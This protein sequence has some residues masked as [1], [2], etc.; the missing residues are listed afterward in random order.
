MKKSYQSY[1]IKI[2]TIHLFTK[3]YQLIAEELHIGDM[4]LQA[5]KEHRDAY[6]HIIRI[7]GIPNSRT[8]PMDVD[9]YIDS[10]FQDAIS[11]E[12]R[13]FCDTADW[14]TIIC[15][16]AIR[17][18][19]N[20]TDASVVKEQYPKF[21]DIDPKIIDFSLRVAKERENKDIGGDVIS[22]VKRYSKLLDEIINYYKEIARAF[23]HIPVNDISIA[24]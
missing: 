24:D 3:H 16:K 19:I 22:K 21:A 7:Y 1:W 4:F 12:Y 8:L 10:N 18:I 23:P 20:Q 5:L 2:C 13:A 6:D 11:H 15:R 17:Y 14:L 9:A